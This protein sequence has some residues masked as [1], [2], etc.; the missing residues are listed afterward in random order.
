MPRSPELAS[1]LMMVH[2]WVGRVMKEWSGAVSGV[3]FGIDGPEAVLINLMGCLTLMPNFWSYEVCWA[4]S[5]LVSPFRYGWMDFVTSSDSLFYVGFVV[6][7]MREQL[8]LWDDPP[9]RQC[10]AFQCFCTLLGHIE[11][12]SGYLTHKNTNDAVSP[13]PFKLG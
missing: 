3:Q 8:V 10:S 5:S 1:L 9:T 11:K 2:M 12:L 13:T 6:G 7:V 4:K